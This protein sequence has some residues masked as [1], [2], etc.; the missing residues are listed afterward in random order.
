VT[1]NSVTSDSK[2][3]QL[4]RSVETAIESG[5]LAQG[6]RLPSVRES[7]KQHSLSLATVTSAYRWLE[8]KGL[9]EAKLK[10]GYFVRKPAVAQPIAV[11]TRP[12]PPASTPWSAPAEL[13]PQQRLQRLMAA[14]VRRHPAVHT[15]YVTDS[16][17]IRLRVELA[18]R[19]AE[20]G[21]FLRADQ[22]II[23][24]G[25]TEA[26]ALALRATTSS[27]DAVA[28][29]RPAHPLFLSLLDSL[30]LTPVFI[31]K[32]IDDAGFVQALQGLRAQ[33]PRLVA[34]LLMTNF[35]FPSG[36]LMPLATKRA[37]ISF[38]SQQQFTIIEDDVFGDLQHDGPRPLPLKSFDTD[39]S[40]IYINSCSKTTAPGLRLGWI[41]AGRWQ[42]KIQQLKLSHASS[43]STLSQA[44]LHDFLAQGSHLP[45]LRKLR[46]SLRE[47]CEKINAILQ[48]ALHDTCLWQLPRGGFAFW[49]ELPA[50][51][52]VTVLREQLPAAAHP[53]VHWLAG[54]ERGFYINGAQ[55]LDSQQISQ[56]ATTL[57]NLQ[58]SHSPSIK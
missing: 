56:L 13:F 57:R 4:A 54:N 33:H 44:V 52:N 41:A 40:I 24:Q 12:A 48:Q 16:G 32:P 46:Q 35:E 58:T 23:T 7:M 38:A 5:Q 15:D 18:R 36:R 39:G 11:A 34:C 10:S 45:H 3:L 19:C 25:A 43:A 31:E 1:V 21:C 53:C 50:C 27:G 6:C 17:L 47:R 20:F 14:A 22:I 51:T 28:I 49:L 55:P 42:Q 8:Q 2:Y 30:A 9:I 26:L 37:L 29:A